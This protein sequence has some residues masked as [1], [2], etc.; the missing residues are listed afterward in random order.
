MAAYDGGSPQFA[1]QIYYRGIPV[2]IV[3]W[4]T[5]NRG[6]LANALFA[7]LVAMGLIPT[8]CRGVSID[9]LQH[10]LEHGCDVDPSDRPIYVAN[11]D[12]AIEYGGDIQVLQIFDPNRLKPSFTEVPTDTPPEELRRLEGLHAS[13]EVS[14]DGTRIWYSKLARND[15]RRTTDYEVA[16]CR[17]IYGHP[18]DALKALIIVHPQ[19]FSTVDIESA[20]GQASR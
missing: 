20:I 15:P 19:E 1:R 7:H 17:C 6:A 16:Y 13:W 11:L 4:H 9:W 18:W 10:I 14:Q 3:G 8:A 2:L 5:K 12:K